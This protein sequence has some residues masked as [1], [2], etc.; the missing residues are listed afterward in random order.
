MLV[1]ALS[2]SVSFE[3]TYIMSELSSVP[4]AVLRS[5]F[6]T[7]ASLTQ[8]MVMFPVAVFERDGPKVSVDW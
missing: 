1:M 7:G 8:F 6:A 4:V 3:V 5:L 2:R